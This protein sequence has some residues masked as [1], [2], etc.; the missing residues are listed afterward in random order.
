MV[1]TA[2]MNK[3]MK[4]TKGMLLRPKSSI[5]RIKDLPNSRHDSGRRSTDPRKR[6]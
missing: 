1:K 5:S 2:P 3:E 4:I 6:K